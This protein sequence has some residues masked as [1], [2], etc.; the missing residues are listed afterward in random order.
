MN[1]KETLERNSV[2]YKEL[3]YQHLGDWSVFQKT[4]LPKLA[5]EEM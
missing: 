2:F 3:L 5:G 4:I 1:K